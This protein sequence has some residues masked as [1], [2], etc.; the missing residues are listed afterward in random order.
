[1]TVQIAVKLGDEEAAALDRLVTEGS[2]ASR[3]EA[4]RTAV[5]ALVH[6]HERHRVDASF[7]EGFRR[8]P[9]S[10]GELTEATR[11]AIGAIEEE[12]WERWW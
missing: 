1:M 11:L 2:F 3:S 10:E 4:V 12:P 7:A 8:R 5:Q 6:G 9:E